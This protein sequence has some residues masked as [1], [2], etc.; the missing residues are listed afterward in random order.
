MENPL[1]PETPLGRRAQDEIQRISVD[2]QGG[3]FQQKRPK[4][5]AYRASPVTKALTDLFHGKCAYCESKISAVGPID[6]DQFHPKAS[7]VEAPGHPGYWW[8]ANSW[9]NLLAACADCNRQ[10]QF[11]GT[12][13]ERAIS[14]KGERFPLLDETARAFSPEDDLELEKPLLLDPTNDQPEEH[15]VYSKDGLVSSDSERGNAT[16]AILG[17]N[18]PGL[19]EQRKYTLGLYRDGEDHLITLASRQTGRDADLSIVLERWQALIQM[20]KEESPYAGMIRQEL[21]RTAARLSREFP[22]LDFDMDMLGVT[23]RLTQD[24]LRRA[25]SATTEYVEKMSD[26]SLDSAAGVEKFKSQRRFVERVTIENIKAIRRLEINFEA[27]SHGPSPWLMLLGENGTG[28]STVLQAIALAL[29]DSEQLLSLLKAKRIDPA[30]LV[31]YRCRSGRI[32]VKLSGFAKPHDIVVYR[33]H[34]ELRSPHGGI[35]VLHAD[36]AAADI[37]ADAQALVLGYG[38]TRLLPRVMAEAKVGARFSRVDNLFDPFVALIDAEAWLLDL[39]PTS[40]HT[41]ALVLKDLLDLEEEVEFVKEGTTSISI[42]GR[43]AKTR[44][45]NLSDGY[46]TIVAMT[47]DIL[48]VL[49]RLWPK[50]TEAEGIVLI[51]EIDAHLH[52]RWQMRIVGSLRNAMP[53]VQF[54]TTT[55]QPLCLRGLVRGEVVVMQRDANGL[56]EP[57]LDLPSPADFRVDQ[58]LTSDFFGL[59][60]TVDPETERLFDTYYALLAL[61]ERTPDQ[62][63]QMQVL[64]S[65]LNGRRQLGDTQRESLYYEAIDTLL[66]KQTTAVRLPPEAL[67]EEVVEQIGALWSQLISNA[68]ADA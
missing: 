20:G 12:D 14:G 67:R 34:L 30:T 60:S 35:T 6:V 40:F 59:R 29:S 42:K 49:S 46:Q 39:G 62:E 38:A 4:F 57:L 32:T 47:V 1:D 19:I 68:G 61:D 2:M 65:E 33:D 66:A 5:T 63:S 21:R 3:A 16:I 17:L 26:Y 23:S 48:D 43:D 11:A 13:G 58:L 28:K 50:L 55:H 37:R 51:D 64:Q 18:R 36:A 53:G 7:V 54:I 24:R 31:R 10:R 22:H 52:P 44:L 9:E 45:R 15:L 8:L 27:L 41:T 56:V 25:Q